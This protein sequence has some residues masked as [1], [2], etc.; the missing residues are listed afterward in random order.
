M[1]ML[2]ARGAEPD[3]PFQFRLTPGRVKTVGRAPRA[4]FVL[5]APLVSRLHCRISVAP[6]G[7][8]EVC[9]LD[10]TNGT[11]INGERVQQ[12]R[13]VEGA[14]LRIGRVEL[15]LERDDQS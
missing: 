7:D 4:D 15:T 3:A 9:D 12:S 5:D 8:V 13:L 11:W 2:R 14:V 6:G 1:W 10:S